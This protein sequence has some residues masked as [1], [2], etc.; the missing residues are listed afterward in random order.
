MDATVADYL[1]HLPALRVALDKALHDP[2]CEADR[3]LKLAW[4]V[5]HLTAV[6]DELAAAA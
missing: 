6:S 1:A 3:F 2:D 4:A 5:A